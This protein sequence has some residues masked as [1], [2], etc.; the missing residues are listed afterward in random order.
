M[1]AA[2][3]CGSCFERD[4]HMEGKLEWLCNTVQSRLVNVDSPLQLEGLKL[5]HAFDKWMI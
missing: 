5:N 3:K 4:A 2:G 1:S